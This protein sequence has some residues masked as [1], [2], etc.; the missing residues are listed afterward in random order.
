MY[1][2]ADQ[3]VYYSR[4]IASRAP[5]LAQ[6][7]W[8]AD[9]VI[10]HEFGHALQG[11][12]GILGGD[13]LLENGAPDQE[14]PAADQPAG[15]NPGRLLLRDVRALGVPVHRHHTVRRRCGPDGRATTRSAPTSCPARAGEHRIRPRTRRHS[16]IL[17]ATPASPRTRSHACNTFT[18]RRQIAGEVEDVPMSQQQWGGNLNWGQS[19]SYNPVA[20]YQQGQPYAAGPGPGY[21]PATGGYG[22]GDDGQAFPGVKGKKWAADV[23]MAHAPAAGPEGHLRRRAPR[24]AEH[25]EQQRRAEVPP[26]RRHQPP[27]VSLRP[28]SG[29]CL[30][31]WASQQADID[32]I[33]ESYAAVGDDTL[34]HNPNVV[35]DHGL[36]R[37]R[38]YWGNLGLGTSP[39]GSATRSAPTT[40]WVR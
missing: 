9:L 8:A 20:P 34:S 25:S 11:R 35:G 29:R 38:R 4:L 15:R 36:A 13:L 26:G 17:G 2:G 40:S 24:I 21:R 33:L 30:V 19:T 28:S 7:P 3:Q 6:N 32:G 5:I 1:C 39:V 18:D 27:T 14:R 12:T 23:I 22:N 16:S 37:S 10:A 31:R